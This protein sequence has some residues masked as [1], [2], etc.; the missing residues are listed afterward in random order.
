MYVV[1]F[2]D[3]TNRWSPVSNYKFNTKVD[4][5]RFAKPLIKKAE[6]HNRKAGYRMV[7]V[8]VWEDKNAP[9]GAKC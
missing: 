4:A 2:H 1:S 9:Q 6:K 3:T 5:D 8:V 7:Q